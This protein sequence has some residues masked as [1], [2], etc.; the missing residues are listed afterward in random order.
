MNPFAATRRDSAARVGTDD[1]ENGLS[2]LTLS[3]LSKMYSHP[4]PG[5]YI[6]LC[7]APSNTHSE[8]PTHTEFTRN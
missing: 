7:H 4:L 6:E 2:N 8:L 1:P 5:Q 3:T